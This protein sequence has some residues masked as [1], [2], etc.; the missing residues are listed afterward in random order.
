VGE[1]WQQ[2]ELKEE[3]ERWPEH[4]RTRGDRPVESCDWSCLRATHPEHI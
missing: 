3:A 2:A 1:G 4:D